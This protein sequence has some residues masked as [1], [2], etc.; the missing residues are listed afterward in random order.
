MTVYFKKGN[1][2]Q[3]NILDKPV[4]VLF[5]V[6]RAIIIG[7]TQKEI[8]R[9]LHV[10]IRIPKMQSNQMSKKRR[11][12]HP[13]SKGHCLRI[14]WQPWLDCNSRQ[15]K[16]TGPRMDVCLKQ[17]QSDFLPG[18]WNWDLGTANLCTWLKLC[19]SHIP[20]SIGAA[21]KGR[22]GIVEPVCKRKD[23][24]RVRDRE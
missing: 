13:T 21:E 22:E 5:S 4:L 16:L 8:L 18:I 15:R 9:H 2:P 20:S 12:R 10:T 14:P 1:Q 19:S 23:E 24:I 7:Q 17:S 11:V 6:Q 3:G